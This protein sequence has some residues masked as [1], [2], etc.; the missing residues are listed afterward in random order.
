MKVTVEREAKQYP[1]ILFGYG[2][3]ADSLGRVSRNILIKSI[4]EP[5]GRLQGMRHVTALPQV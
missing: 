4:E 1:F 2:K 3:Q 5:L